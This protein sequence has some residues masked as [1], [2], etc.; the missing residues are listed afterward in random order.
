METTLQKEIPAIV[1][2]KR[3]N[4]ATLGEAVHY[5]ELKLQ[6]QAQASL[7]KIKIPSNIS[8]V[9][10]AEATLKEVKREKS[11]VEINRKTATSRLDSITTR[12]ML[13]EKSFEL[14]LKTL[15]AAIITIKKADQ[16]KRAE[17]EKKEKQIKECRE[18]LINHKNTSIS[19]FNTKIINKVDAAYTYALGDGNITIEGLPKF[20]ET[21]SGAFK[22]T[23]FTLLAPVNSFSLISKDEYEL[24]CK[25]Q[26]N[27][28]ASAF[29]TD[30]QTK[31]RH[32]FSDFEIAINNKVQ[33]LELARKEKEDQ[34]KKIAEE[35]A[36]AEMAAK[37]SAVAITP[38]VNDSP[39]KDL[40]ASWKID[41]EEN[42]ENSVLVMTA[43]VSNISI[44]KPMLKVNKFDSF[45]VGQMK[46]YLCKCKTLDSNF[47]FTGLTFKSIDKL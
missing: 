45:T 8:D 35:K 40:K 19:A 43:F 22:L 3:T 10:E 23:D 32:K 13:P 33:A 27:S 20:L 16:E 6:A 29:I 5:L 28:D 4:W 24:M 17:I 34:E 14:P 36:N 25:E 15:E 39:V 46:T 41:L 2:E 47:S 12:L 11:E 1:L 18:Y 31:L 44:I 9:A 37:L 26:T 30:Y 38:V 7:A 42:L 21:A